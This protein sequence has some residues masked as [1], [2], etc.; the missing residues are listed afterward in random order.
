VAG[1]CPDTGT[2]CQ[3]V[4]AAFVDMCCKA[5]G[6]SC[7]IYSECCSLSCTAGVCD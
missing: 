6:G 2:T 7:S 3:F 4:E 1:C 5:A